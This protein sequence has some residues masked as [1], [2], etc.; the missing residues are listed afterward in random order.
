VGAPPGSHARALAVAARA[1]ARGVACAVDLVARDAAA[2]AAYAAAHG[3][4]AVVELAPAGDPDGDA[5]G[6]A[7][8]L[9]AALARATPSV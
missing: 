2:R 9:D 8:R 3:F 7:A 1:R 5:A 4:G 6:D